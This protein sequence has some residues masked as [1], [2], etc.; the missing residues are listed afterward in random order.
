MNRIYEPDEARFRV[1]KRLIMSF[2]IVSAEG[3]GMLLKGE[4]PMSELRQILL[5]LEEEEI[6]VKGFLKEDS[7]TLYWIVKDDLDRVKGHLFQGSF[8]LNQLID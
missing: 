3:L 1:V 6:L 4:I 5:R 8:V 2:G 7:E